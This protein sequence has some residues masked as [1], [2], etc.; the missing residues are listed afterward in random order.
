[1]KQISCGMS[2]DMMLKCYKYFI[3]YLQADYLNKIFPDKHFEGFGWQKLNLRLKRSYVSFTCCC[4]LKPQW[5][6]CFLQ[7]CA[8]HVILISVSLFDALP[9]TNTTP[10]LN[11]ILIHEKAHF[12]KHTLF[13]VRYYFFPRILYINAHN[14]KEIIKSYF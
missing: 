1:M 6:E 4:Q 9:G 12:R 11:G 13:K 2:T 3:N 5:V 8:K 14:I 7:D 10:V